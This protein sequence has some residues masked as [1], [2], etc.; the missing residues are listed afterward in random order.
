MKLNYKK[1][2]LI[3]FNPGTCRD[4]MPKFSISN[5]EIEMV[6]E[7]KLLG[8][9]VRSDLSWSANTDYIVERA[10]KKLW[11]LRRLKK[12]GAN[13]DDLKEIYIK[14]IR[15]VLEFAVPVWHS[16]LTGVDRL[17]IERVQKSALHIILGDRYRSYT[18]ALKLL[19]L[20]PL[21]NRRH[22]LVKKFAKKCFGNS[23]FN[24]WFKIN[25]KQTVTRLDQPRL[26]QVYCR[27]DRFE[28]S[29]IS[30]ITELL[31]RMKHL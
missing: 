22:K 27:L 19:S 20:E 26:C 2:K 16:S 18:S 1:T 15:S 17:R 6:E 7:V 24:K 12:L 13:Q 3:L 4:F 5:N 8:V 29:P 23:K 31:N 11:I 14:Q 30:Y 9:V 10:N 21:F 28:R 25:R